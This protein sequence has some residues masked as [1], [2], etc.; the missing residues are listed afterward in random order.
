MAKQPITDEDVLIKET[1]RLRRIDKRE[2]RAIS[3][4]KISADGV[5]YWVE[6][7]YSLYTCGYIAGKR[8]SSMP[9]LSFWVK[10]KNR[11]Y[12]VR[13]G[14]VVLYEGNDLEKAI[15]IYN[16]QIDEHPLRFDED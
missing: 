2:E 8:P 10:M 14:H 11:M 3:P 4:E 7:W 6:N 12:K 1:M 9:F 5:E 13:V 15:A 16:Q